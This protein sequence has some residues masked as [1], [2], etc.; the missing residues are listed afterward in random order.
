M[1]TPNPTA[2]RNLIFGLLA[3]QMDFV[4]REQ[5]L[6]GMT[7]WMLQKQTP[8]GEILCQRGVLSERRLAMLQGL[9]EE[10]IAQHG[11]DPQ[12]SLAA[13][14]VEPGVRHYLS[15]LPDPDVQ[16]SVSSLVSTPASAGPGTDNGA[17]DSLASPATTAPA[18]GVDTGVRYR[19]LREHARGGLGEVFVALDGELSRE[20]ALKEIQ[21]RFADHPAYR[22]RFLREAEITGH[23]EHPGVVP[24]YGL[25]V[26]PDGRPYYA[27]RLIRGEPMHDAVRRFHKA[28]EQPGRDAGERAL[29]LR[30]LLGRF[31]A[32][33]NAVA[34]AHARGVIHR[35]LKPANVML[36][37]Y[38][39]TLVVDWGLARVLDQPESQD[40][41]A[42]RPVQLGAGSGS[43]PTEMGQVVGTPA[44]MPPE[45]AQGQHDRVGI[46]SDVFALGAT[47]YTLLTGQA[48]YDRQD[49]L[50]QAARGEVMPARQRKRSVP[51]A[52]EAV[53]H[54]A[55]AKQPEDRY[56]TARVLAKEVQRWLAGEP[57]EAW[58]EPLVVKAGRW[59]REHR[60][61]ATSTVVALV[62]ALVLGTAGGV[63]W[64]QQRRWARDQ[65]ELALERSV[66]LRHGYR[67]RDAQTMLEQ[68]GEWASQ[69]HDRALQARLVQA[70]RELDLA[71]DLDDV[72]QKAAIPVEGKWGNERMRQEYPRVLAGHGL[73]V[74]EGDPEELA[75]A[76]RASAVREDIVAALD[77][78]A[79]AERR[80]QNWQKQQRLL[81][82][83]N[84]ADEPDPWRQAVRLALIQGD[85]ERLRHLVRG[86]GQGKPTPAV[87]LLLAASFPEQSAKP[88]DLLRRIQRERP[89]DV[90]V[91]VAVGNRLFEQQRYREAAD[92]VLLAVALRPDSAGLHTA[93]GAALRD[94]GEVEEAIACYQKAIAL[95]PK[96]AM[97]HNNLGAALHDKGEVEAAIACHRKAIEID[98]KLALAH[99]NLGSALLGKGEVVAA[100]ACFKK[101]IDHDPKYAPAHTNLGIAL[102]DAGKADA[103]IACYRK[104]IEIDPKDAHAHY[105]LGL[106]LKDRGEVDAAIA[107][108]RKAIELEPKYAPAHYNLGAALAGKGQVDAAIASYKKAIDLDPKYAPAHTNLGAA[109]A[110]KG[111]V[112]AAIEYYRKAIELDPKHAYAHNNLGNALKGKGAL[113]EAI[114]CYQKAI[115]LDPKYAHAHSNLGNALQR[116]GEVDTAIACYKKAI[117]FDPKYAMAY[118]NLGTALRDK[119]E[120]EAAIACY[121][122]ALGL[123]PKLAM[124]H[125]NMGVAL[126]GKGK[127][128]EA[129]TCYQKAIA[130]AP[131]D[132]QAHLNLGLALSAKGEVE[133]A[134][135]C[136]KKA[137][138]IDPKLA[139]AHTSLGNVLYDKGE[140]EKAVACYRKAIALESKYAGAHYALGNALARKGEVEAAIACYKKA[141]EFDP[142]LAW[143]H[144]NLGSALLGKG[145]VDAAIACF[146]KAIE[147]D[148]RDA[149]AYTNL[150]A[151]LQRKGEVDEAIACYKKAIDLDPK[152][153]NAHAG[154][155]QVLMQRGEFSEACKAL[156][157]CLKL[158][159]PRSS[160][161][162]GFASGLLQQAQQSLEAEDKLKAFLTGKGAPAEAARLVQMAT[163]ARQPFKRLYLT[164]TR[165]YRD[166]FASQ[167][168]LA[169][170]HRYNA[171]CT[172]ALASTGQ[173]NDIARLEETAKAELRYSALSWLQD[174]LSSTFVHFERPGKE[175]ALLVQ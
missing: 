46:A 78:W 60:V 102:K 130:L 160:P 125:N 23:L 107:C 1:A 24:V 58:P 126:H 113:E 147:I 74:L 77:D 47:L 42:E 13:L 57:V 141:I 149:G 142:K 25:G 68:A 71:S 148:P 166:A 122:K 124:A 100:I 63:Y 85:L 62:V 154:L 98:P 36:G 10:H 56:H 83:A 105:N 26:Y 131:K 21:E 167:P 2:D 101:A 45:Q 27:M 22:A 127:V 88:T 29:E 31:V 153:P 48:P 84:L 168:S 95:D 39:E 75:R 133:E 89:G 90:W 145:E 162:R 34:Y 49:V 8:L 170:A 72:R 161:L 28:D 43:T 35:D 109:L 14:R 86:T 20:V 104:A 70:R 110:G 79:R 3:L 144:S 73:D 169:T 128:D 103:A 112:D 93:L 151:A 94:K 150:G 159:P 115:E 9:V 4:S 134:I 129:I 41:V 19:R 173:G 155:G 114:A 121:Q 146:K 30:D 81:R 12:A 15:R 52:L 118:N 76:I 171:A 5:L 33:C 106:A 123:D 51:A 139:Q 64:Q 117:E 132:A 80:L 143:A 11:G 65:A 69:A 108:V 82:L 61:L 99:Y 59:L 53:C 175:G 16:G 50:A 7:A 152:R 119:G 165:L 158:L 32:V 135:A 111:E 138:E 156:R 157:R 120:V 92:S 38:G 66:E 67:F 44:F 54:K 136:Y 17:A 174:H 55:M 96:Y 40:T 137:I 163:L 172:A 140:V 116:K 97:A 6:E 87:V 164:S 37:E 91:S 18:G